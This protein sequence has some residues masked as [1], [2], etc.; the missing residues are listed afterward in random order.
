MT[1]KIQERRLLEREHKIFQKAKRISWT[2]RKA[3]QESV[4]LYRLRGNQAERI[5]VQFFNDY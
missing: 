5:R 1:T 2:V 3:W 4:I